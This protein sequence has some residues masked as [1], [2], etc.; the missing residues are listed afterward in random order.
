VVRNGRGKTPGVWDRSLGREPASVW[1]DRRRDCLGLRPSTGGEVLVCVRWGGAS[2][3][4]ASGCLRF[5]DRLWVVT[6]GNVGETV[7]FVEDFNFKS[8]DNSH[9]LDIGG[10]LRLGRPSGVSTRLRSCDLPRRV[11]CPV[12]LSAMP[13]ASRPA[14]SPAR[15]RAFG[16]LRPGLGLP[17]CIP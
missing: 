12:H 6:P 2:G 5:R 13:S 8:P 1:R 15:S 16:R 3:S 17:P 14:S 10:E 4:S 11:F 9:H 7:G